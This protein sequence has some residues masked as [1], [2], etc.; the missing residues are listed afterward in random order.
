MEIETSSVI[1]V[2]LIDH[3]GTDNTICNAARVSTGNDVAGYEESQGLINYLWREGHTSPFEHASMTFRID[4]PL[5]IARQV[6][7]HRTF[8]FN[9]ISGR[10]SVLE[11]KFWVPNVNRPLHNKGSGAYPDLQHFEERD[12]ISQETVQAISLS[13]HYAM[14]TYQQLLDLGVAS[15]VAR[16]VLPQNMYTQFYMSG[17]LKN[18]LD[19]ISKRAVPNAQLEIQIMADLMYYYVQDNFPMVIEAYNQEEE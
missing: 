4:V 12:K 15:E 10:Y 5:F 8:S 13:T 17:N 19:F 16:V 14:Q 11:P 9:E 18:V 6:M 7:R 2:E 3:M 1:G